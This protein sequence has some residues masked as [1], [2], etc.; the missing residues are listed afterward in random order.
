MSRRIYIESLDKGYADAIRRGFDWLGG[1]TRIRN[2][3]RVCIKPNLTFPRFRR[4]VMTNPDALESLVIYLRNH[5]DRITICESDSGGYN[6]FSMD[7]VFSATGTYEMA[8]RYGVQVVNMSHEPSRPI[9]VIVGT[10]KMF[11]PLPS[12]LLD[13]T[14]LFVTMP[15]PK[16]HSNTIVSLSIKNQWGVIQDP[17]LRLKLHPYFKDV[18]YAVNK[19]LPRTISVV[20]G[21]YGLTRSGPLRGDIVELNWLLLCDNIYCADFVC[22]EL[23]R[24]DHKKVPYLRSIFEKEGIKNLD[25]VVFN[26]DYRKFIAKEA[27]YLKREWTDYPGLLTFN[28]RFLAYIGYHS[29]LAK[30]LHWLLYRFREPFY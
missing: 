22:C 10:K 11:I 18:V 26:Q 29:P 20:D 27:F 25:G 23:M 13:E 3:D 17:P 5:T 2:S 24:V 28:S 15:V 30:P 21:K 7:E 19:A 12:L 16:V 14:D 6:R 8:R 9:E 1:P 4:G